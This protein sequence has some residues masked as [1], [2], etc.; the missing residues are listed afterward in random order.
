MTQT[1]NQYKILTGYI[2]EYPTIRLDD[3]KVPDNVGYY[4]SNI[5]CIPNK[6]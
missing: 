5:Q 4:F 6:K 1:I 2:I 3:K